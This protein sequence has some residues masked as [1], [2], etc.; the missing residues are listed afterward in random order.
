[1]AGIELRQVARWIVDDEMTLSHAVMT[2]RLTNDEKVA[3]KQLIRDAEDA[4]IREAANLRVSLL[5]DMKV[6][7]GQYYPELVAALMGHGSIDLEAGGV[8]DCV[9]QFLSANCTLK[10]EELAMALQLP[11]SISEPV[12]C[13]SEFQLPDFSYQ[14]RETKELEKKRTDVYILGPA[15]VGKSSLICSLIAQL[16]EQ[17]NAELEVSCSDKQQQEYYN[18]VMECT[19]EFTKFPVPSSAN[20]FLTCP[21]HLKGTRKHLTIIDSGRRGMADLGKSMSVSGET[22]AWLHRLMKNDNAK[23]VF[24]VLDFGVLSENNSRTVFSHISLLERAVRTLY[25]DGQGDLGHKNCTMSKVKALGFIFNK[26]DTLTLD[27]A[28]AKQLAL[29][30]V[31]ENMKSIMLDTADVCKEL[32]VNKEIE[33]QPYI[34]VH[35]LGQPCV[36]HTLQY[37]PADSRLLAQMIVDACPK[38]GLFGF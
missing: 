20:T 33:N 13:A 2:Y 32:G 38:R 18:T 6:H 28:E 30:F 29:S 1:M 26:Y 12:L 3:L 8:P 15:C 5:E 7:P 4:A 19:R 10:Y 9:Q 37:N 25:S 11:P 36:S 31:N 17:H 16:C 27:A 34:L 14:E 35:S 24:F 23:I 22:E 21:L